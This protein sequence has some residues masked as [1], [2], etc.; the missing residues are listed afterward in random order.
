MAVYQKYN[1]NTQKSVWIII[2][3]FQQGKTALWN[4]F[5]RGRQFMNPTDLH[6]LLMSVEPRN[7]RWYLNDIREQIFQY[8]VALTSSPPGHCKP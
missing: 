2:Q 4:H 3:P 7:W 8:V 5:P 6:A 1:F